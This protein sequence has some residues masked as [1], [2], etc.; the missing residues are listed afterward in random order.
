[1]GVVVYTT[2][3]AERRSFLFIFKCIPL[4]L[5]QLPAGKELCGHWSSSVTVTHI[6]CI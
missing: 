2:V 4:A 5:Q 1:M 6:D 3:T